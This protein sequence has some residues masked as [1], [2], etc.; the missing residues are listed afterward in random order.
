MFTNSPAN[1]DDEWDDKKSPSENVKNLFK[2]YIPYDFNIFSRKHYVSK[3]KEIIGVIENGIFNPRDQK[4]IPL[5]E[6]NRGAEI[7]NVYFFLRTCIAAGNCEKFFIDHTS[8]EFNQRLNYALRKLENEYDGI[9]SEA[10]KFN[11]NP[12]HL[13]R[14]RSMFLSR[15]ENY[16]TTPLFRR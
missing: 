14:G 15:G 5:Q 11:S 2:N 16:T 10:D 4:S 3:A 7:F 6:S 1:F 8:G 12:H 13:W 9:K